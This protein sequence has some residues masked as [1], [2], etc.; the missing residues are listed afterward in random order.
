MP[1]AQTYGSFGWSGRD[2]RLA[3][4]DT[5]VVVRGDECVDLL[6]DEAALMRWLEAGQEWLGAVTSQEAPALG[7]VLQLREAIRGGWRDGS[8][9]GGSAGG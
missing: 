7:D 3:L 9:G 2:R 5:I 4:A 6:E 8:A 1:Q